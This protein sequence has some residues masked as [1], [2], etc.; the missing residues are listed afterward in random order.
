MRPSPPTAPVPAPDTGRAYRWFDDGA[1][2]G[3]G[4]SSV[5]VGA[6]LLGA[7]CSAAVLSDTG[8]SDTGFQ[9]VSRRA[10]A[11]TAATCSRVN[12][13]GKPRSDATSAVLVTTV[14]P[15]GHW[16]TVSRPPTTTIIGRTGTRPAHSGSP[17]A[18]RAVCRNAAT[19]WA[20]RRA[21]GTYAV[22]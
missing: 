12:T 16:R 11:Y 14:T 3:P 18:V 1:C 2:A 5:L 20:S 9:V 17:A 19:R 22:R 6:G 4:R 10:S 13:V 15:A 8:W 21:L 7:G